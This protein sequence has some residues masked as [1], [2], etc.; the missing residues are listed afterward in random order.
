M[1]PFE[2][3]G[4][5]LMWVSFLLL[6]SGGIAIFFLWGIRSGQFSNQDRARYLALLAEIPTEEKKE[7]EERHKD[8]HGRRQP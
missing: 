4:F 7:K 6:M 5:V 1:N 3:T 2:G 8:E